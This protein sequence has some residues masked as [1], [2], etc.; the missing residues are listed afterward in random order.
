MRA[1][2]HIVMMR[3]LSGDSMKNLLLF[4]VFIASCAEDPHL[5]L[6]K[7]RAIFNAQESLVPNTLKIIPK[8]PI[9]AAKTTAFDNNRPYIAPLP[10]YCD[11][12]DFPSNI[13]LTAS[14]CRPFLNGFIRDGYIADRLRRD[15]GPR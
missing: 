14:A 3:A 7:A 9:V 10:Y 1:D 8:D 12:N 13:V 11:P 4:L 6:G 5:E 15:F 2:T